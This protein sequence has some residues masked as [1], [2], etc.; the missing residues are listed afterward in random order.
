MGFK[1]L[2]TVQFLGHMNKIQIY[3]FGDYFQKG[4]RYMGR[5]RGERGGTGR[6]FL[7]QRSEMKT[8]GPAHESH[9]HVIIFIP[10]HSKWL[11][12]VT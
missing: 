8:F 7:D 4:F 12:V 6:N 11:L 9:M 5:S 10:S 2:Y 3:E 1:S